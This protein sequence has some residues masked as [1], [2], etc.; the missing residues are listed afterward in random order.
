MPLHLLCALSMHTLSPRGAQ[1]ALGAGRFV[2]GAASATVG[3]PN[4]SRTRGAAQPHVAAACH[5]CGGGGHMAVKKEENDGA[6][7]SEPP[8]FGDANGSGH[9]RECYNPPEATMI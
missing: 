3:R 8:G 7:S 4:S 6:T 9:G 2:L 5:R 1:P